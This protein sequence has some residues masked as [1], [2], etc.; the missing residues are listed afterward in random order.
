MPA[1][2][3][4]ATMPRVCPAMESAPAPAATTPPTAQTHVP[5]RENDQCQGGEDQ[6][7]HSRKPHRSGESLL[8]HLI[9][10]R[11]EVEG[12]ERMRHLKNDEASHA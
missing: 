3:S 12:H 5:P 9:E 8:P 2:K 7:G 1:T 10:Q 6:P 11:R 4:P